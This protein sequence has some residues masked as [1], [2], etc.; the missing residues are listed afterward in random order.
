M[1]QY[2]K[3]NFLLNRTYYD[4]ETLNEQGI[5]WLYRT[6]NYLPHNFTK[7]PPEEAFAEEINYLKSYYPITLDDQ[8]DMKK[9][10]VR[11]T[12]VIAFR[13][14]F[15]SLAKGTYKG[16]GSYVLVKP[17]E[18]QLL[19]YDKDEQIIKATLYRRRKAKPSAILIT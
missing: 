9:Y 3:K 12:N 15:Y 17:V 19:I 1:I 14:N 8:P 6:A 10:I 16:P 11:K 13:S 4:I 5:A 2:I 18:D 7:I